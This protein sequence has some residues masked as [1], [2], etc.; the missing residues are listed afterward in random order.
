MHAQ[1]LKIF[2][3]RSRETALRWVCDFVFGSNREDVHYAVH[4]LD[5]VKVADGLRSLV[6]R[7]VFPDLK[8]PASSWA[9][10]A[11]TEPL[12]CLPS[13]DAQT[14]SL[15][16]S[17]EK[18]PILYGS[19]NV[20]F[21][22]EQITCGA[23]LFGGIFFMLSRFEEIM[24][25]E[26]DVH[27]RFS[28]SSSLAR[29]ENFLLEPLAD[30]YREMILSFVNHLWPG[31][32]RKKSVGNMKVSCDVDEPFDR[33]VRSPKAFSRTVGGDILKRRNMKLAA[34]R[35]VNFAFGRMIG[36]RF[37]PCH[38]FDWYM[39]QCEAHGLRATFYFIAGNSAGLID[40][41]YQI[42]EPKIAELMRSIV[43]RGHSIG[44]HGSYNTYKDADRLQQERMRLIAVLKAAGI[45]QDVI[46][47]RQHYLRWD[48]SCTPDCLYDAGFRVDTS[49]GFADLPGFRYGTSRPFRM[50][51]WKKLK[52]LDLIQ[53]PLIVME[54]SL[55]SPLYQNMNGAEALQTVQTLKRVCTRYGGTLG[56][57]WHNSQLLTKQERAIFQAI[58]GPKLCG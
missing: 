40:G 23:D 57:L 16:D 36:P 5:E 49:G 27:D 45:A 6:V 8:S 53:K 24:A 46:E 30:I 42:E 1:T 25:S 43:R 38:T 54:G 26:R 44:M 33:S 22:E 29:R 51:S 17:P 55:L 21:R 10:Q 18:I 52:P 37:D 39:T 19:A 3:P 14:I 50:W 28:G 56:I 7:S 12:I 32:E 20:A 41:T 13:K 31:W 47:N 11:P 35:F 4:D 58:L 34:K 48:A 15:P 9:Q 2:L